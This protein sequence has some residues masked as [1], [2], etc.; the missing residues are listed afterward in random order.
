MLPA[1]QQLNV[2]APPVELLGV[3]HYIVRDY[4]KPSPILHRVWDDA[5]VDVSRATAAVM[6]ALSNRGAS[7]GRSLGGL[8]SVQVQLPGRVV[9]YKNWDTESF[10]VMVDPVVIDE[11]Q[12][13]VSGVEG[14]FSLPAGDW[15]Y[16][17]RPKLVTIE[18]TTEFGRMKSVL[19]GM[20]ARFCLHEIDHLNGVLINEIGRKRS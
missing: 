11:S 17:D 2:T 20:N 16:V 6:L 5:P 15:F 14:C 4:P 8:S 9:T 3:E 10:Y 13:K 18:H 19:A 7:D 12:E 1:V